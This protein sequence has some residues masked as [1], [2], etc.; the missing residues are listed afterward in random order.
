MLDDP[1]IKQQ[2]GCEA[3]SIGRM[4][5]KQRWIALAIWSSVTA[6]AIFTAKLLPSIYRAEAVVLVN[7]QKIPE[8]F[9]S[10]TVS[11][12]VTDR[13]ALVTQRIMTSDRLL[14]IVNTFGLYRYAR[15]R[16]TQDELLAKMRQDISVKFEKNW[17][18]DRMKA[19]RL[20]YQGQSAKTVA[21]V[22]N[23][24][25]GLYV[26]ENIQSREDQAADTVNFLSGQLRA[27]KSSLDEQE[28]R[29]ASFKQEH[30][31]TLPEQENSLLATLNSLNMELQGTETSVARAEE[32]KSTL[33]AVLA[34]AESS[35]SA[36]KANRRRELKGS[37]SNTAVP[38]PTAASVAA[39]L[40]ILRQ[41][42][43]A[44]HPEVQALEAELAEIKRQEAEDLAATTAVKPESGNDARNSDISPELIQSRERIAGLRAQIEVAKHQI[45]ALEKQRDDLRAAI[46]TCQMR[47]SHLPLVEQQMAS[48]KRN[49]DESANNY[50]SLLQKTIAA[51]IATDMERSQKSEQFTIIDPA[52]TP[53]KP[54]RPNRFLIALGGSVAGLMLGLL[55]GFL[56][57][58]RKRKLLGE[59][60]LPAGTVILGRIPI[61]KMVPSSL[62]AQGGALLIAILVGLQY[63]TGPWCV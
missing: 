39:Q 43:T 15:R 61:I 29:V 57:E 63:V 12:D 21:E 49:Y 1:E 34:S 50:N 54:E 56:W 52:R 6:I 26:A 8:A 51:G 33:E 32:N 17:T 5:W 44:D 31:G 35:D 38:I 46:T 20:G 13:L 59:W 10:P 28:K 2:N 23:R 14:N 60:E 48:L 55:T 9:V 47:V 41:K 22:A 25:A 45:E 62:D 4:L 16:L 7:S 19:F 24:L 58:F 30:N 11:G 53:D 36:I 40:R 42:Y 18:G 3:L 37:A 27:A